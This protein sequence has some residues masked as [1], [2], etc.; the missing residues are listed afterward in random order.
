MILLVMK[1]FVVI[2]ALVGGLALVFVL[3]PRAS[4]EPDYTPPTLPADLDAYLTEAEARFADLRPEVE[5]QIVWADSSRRKTP[6]AVVYLHGFSA[7]RQETRPL[8]DTLAARLGANLF[9][10]RLTGHGRTDDAL[11]EAT[12]EDWLADAAEAL[13][14]G[15]RLG[16]RVVLVGTSTGATLGVWLA[17]QP[18]TPDLLALVMISPNFY[19]K[20]PSARFLLWPWGKQLLRLMQGEYREWPPRNERQKLYWTTRYPSRVLVEL[21]S[22]VDLVEK[23]DLGR[24]SAPTLVLYS[25]NDQVISAARIEARFPEIGA[26]MKRLV[27]VEV[28]GDSSNHVI[29]GDVLSPETTLPLADEIFDFLQPLLGR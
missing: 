9:Y 26:S 27:P 19:P 6:V 4:V 11:G 16:E 22:L 18:A 2:L 13:A 25:P 8:S 15:Q 3:G 17:A 14:I 24:I 28:S 12:A 10:T 29:A 1:A 20:D 5:K 7:T 21:M 23:T